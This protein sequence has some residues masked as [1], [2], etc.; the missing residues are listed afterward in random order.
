M[1]WQD[2]ETIVEIGV[3]EVGADGVVVAGEEAVEVLEDGWTP[4]DRKKTITVSPH[5]PRCVC[6]HSA[7]E[8]HEHQVN[9]TREE[10][11]QAP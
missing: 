7:P 4:C 8:L 6:P 10:D 9:D 11:I 1:E 2:E 3:E 5:I